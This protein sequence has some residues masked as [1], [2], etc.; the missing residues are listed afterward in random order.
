MND[1]LLRSYVL[2]CQQ[3][4][5]AFSGSHLCRTIHSI[6]DQGVESHGI[7]LFY[8]SESLA[9]RKDIN[10]DF[11]FEG[12]ELAD[13]AISSDLGKVCISEYSR[14]RKNSIVHGADNGPLP[15]ELDETSH[16][17]VDYVQRI[18]VML[19]G[20]SGFIEEN[21]RPNNPAS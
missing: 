21:P 9:S 20:I 7:S 15:D 14:D 6:N 4:A 3:I 19:R 16:I 13:W 17:C 8:R 18:D 1:E 10:I 12:D 2:Y 5:D 11:V